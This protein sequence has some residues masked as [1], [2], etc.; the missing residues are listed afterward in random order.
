MWKTKDF[1]GK[2]YEKS[3]ILEKNSSF[4]QNYC[5]LLSIL[6]NS[7]AIGLGIVVSN[8]IKP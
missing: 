4:P 2:H 7:L 3:N 6:Q 5:F 8:I 1:C